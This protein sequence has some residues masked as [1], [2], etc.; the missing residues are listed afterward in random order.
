MAPPVKELPPRQR[1]P[2]ALTGPRP[3]P[4]LD[5]TGTQLQV[6]ISELDPATNIADG[7]QLEINQA[8]ISRRMSVAQMKATTAPDLTQFLTGI[9]PGDGIQ[10]LGGAPVP[11]VMLADVGAPGTFGDAANVPQITVDQYGRVNGV[12]LVPIPQPN[13]S[14][15]APLAS[16]AFTG[17]PTA[18]TA[19]PGDAD[20]SLATT[21]FVQNAITSRNLAPIESPAFTGNPT[22]PTPAPGDADTSIATT[23]FVEARVAA[24]VPVDLSGYAPIAS[25]NFTGDPRAPTPA[26]IEADTSIATTAFVKGQNYVTADSPALTG[27]PTAPTPAAED[28]DT[29]IAT[30]AF[31]AAA[32]ASG[33]SISVGVAPPASPKPNQLWWHAELGQMFIYY[34]DGDTSQWVPASPAANM[35]SPGGEFAAVNS[36]GFG[37][38]VNTPTVIGPNTV[39]TGNSGG[40]YNPANGRYTPPAGRYFIFG[41]FS[42]GAPGGASGLQISFRKNGVAIGGYS[43]GTSGSANWNEGATNA[44]IVDASGTDYFELVLLSGISSNVSS[45]QFMAFPISGIKGPPGD[46]GAPV[47]A[48]NVR[49]TVVD[50]VSGP[51]NIPVFRSIMA[52]VKDH[53]PDNVWDLANARFTAPSAGRYWFSCHVYGANSVAS[54]TGLVLRHSTAAGAVIRDYMQAQVGDGTPY[55]SDYNVTMELQM[56][57]GERVSFHVGTN[58]G[59]FAMAPSSSSVGGL[60]G[61]TLCWASGRKV[62]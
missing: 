10:V 12:A 55:G 20:T 56:G 49:S 57:A 48:F 32:I 8:G 43:W 23:G 11:T 26:L 5:E 35:T 45:V 58:A 9:V 47:A 30:T 13:L 1:A 41:T 54:L 42:A 61:A 24:I 4:L 38:P 53:D 46:I 52:P 34:N 2:R 39:Q 29:S 18:P 59:N 36:G 7:D 37:L 62:V 16:P 60:L 40:W 17:N 14:G 28:N 22:A 50:T 21:S 27:N 3:A 19:A 25:P 15:Y 31:V 51:N 44:Q 6:R 33:A